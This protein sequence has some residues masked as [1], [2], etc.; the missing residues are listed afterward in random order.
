M[1]NFNIMGGGGV[2]WKIKFLMGVPGKN[3][4]IRYINIVYIGRCFV[5]TYIESFFQQFAAFLP[6]FLGQ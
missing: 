4:K 3:N 2:Q 5:L 6:V 1:K